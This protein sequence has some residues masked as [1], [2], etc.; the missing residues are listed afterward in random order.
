MLQV[1][2]FLDVIKSHV[3]G[4]VVRC[5]CSCLPAC[6]VPYRAVS[7]GFRGWR[8]GAEVRCREVRV[9]WLVLWCRGVP[10][11]AAGLA[12]RNIPVFARKG[13]RARGSRVASSW[14]L[15]CSW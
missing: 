5:S 6:R 7:C 8:V 1:L 14:P 13:R 15:A 3:S 12:R 4:S 9:A 2:G 11:G 10:S